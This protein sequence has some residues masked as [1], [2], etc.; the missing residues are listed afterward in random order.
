[1]DLQKRFPIYHA[2]PIHLAANFSRGLAILLVHEEKEITQDDLEREIIVHCVQI[3]HLKNDFRPTFLS[4]ILRVE[5]PDLSS[6]LPTFEYSQYEYHEVL[7]LDLPIL[8]EVELVLVWTV[9]TLFEYAQFSLL[10]NRLFNSQ[11]LFSA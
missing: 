8:R 6:I 10:E 5:I 4:K 7:V 9:H 1:M 3:R 11:I 2:Y